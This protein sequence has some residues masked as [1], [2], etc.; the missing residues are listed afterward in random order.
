MI[1]AIKR[2][3]DGLFWNEVT[4]QFQQELTE[5]CQ[6]G[7]APITAEIWEELTLRG[8]VVDIVRTEPLSGRRIS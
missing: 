1:W 6:V 2:A 4:A 8:E 3:T 7:D 5:H